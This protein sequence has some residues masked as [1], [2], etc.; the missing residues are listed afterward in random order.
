[1]TT[2]RG[3]LWVSVALF[4]VLDVTV[5]ASKWKNVDRGGVTNIES[6]YPRPKLLTKGKCILNGFRSIWKNRS[7]K[8]FPNLLVFINPKSGGNKV[9]SCVRI[10]FMDY[11]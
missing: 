10:I 6:S 2:F 7:A 11:S 1:M 8:E 4:S 3:I 5:T 9:S